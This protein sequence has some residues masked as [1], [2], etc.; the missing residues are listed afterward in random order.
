MR[1]T[2]TVMLI[3]EPDGGYVVEVPALPGCAT[4]GN[5]LTEALL[6]AEDAISGYLAVLMEDG[7]EIP[8]EG[9]E[10][11]V[12]LGINREAILRKVSVS[13]SVQA[14]KGVA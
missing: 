7:D 6:M 9:S 13:A 5:T 14:E 8:R 1:Y 3:P 10:L 2:Y 11:T 4:E 12:R